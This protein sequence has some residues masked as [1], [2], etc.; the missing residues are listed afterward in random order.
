MRMILDS[1]RYFLDVENSVTGRP[2]VDRLDAAALRTATAISQRTELSEILARIVAARSIAAHKAT[3]LRS[4]ASRSRT[5]LASGRRP[6]E[7]NGLASSGESKSDM[8][9]MC[10]QWTASERAGRS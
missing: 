8:T 3:T 5:W 2:W 7:T 4:V 10:H 6:V 1:P 9:D